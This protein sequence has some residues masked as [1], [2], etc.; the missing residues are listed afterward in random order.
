VVIDRDRD[1]P[2]LGRAQDV[3]CGAIARILDPGGVA[4]VDQDARGKRQPLLGSRDQHDLFGSAAH[5]ARRHQVFGDRGAQP[6][7]TLRIAIAPLDPRPAGHGAR[8]EALPC[9]DETPVD[10]GMAELERPLRSSRRRHTGAQQRGLARQGARCRAGVDRLGRRRER[11]GTRRHVVA[12]ARLGGDVA[13]C[14]QLLEH[15]YDRAAC[16]P[17]LGRER[18]ARRQ[19]RAVGEA[20]FRDRLAQRRGELTRQRNARIAVEPRRPQRRSPLAQRWMRG[21]P[22]G[23]ACGLHRPSLAQNPYTAGRRRGWP[24]LESEGMTAGPLV[25]TYALTERSRAI[26]AEELQA[27]A[28][29]VYLTDLKPE[30]RAE[31]LHSAGALLSHDTSKELHPGEIPLI[32]GARLLQFTAAG[33]DWVP[34]RGLPPELPVAANKGGGAEP[35]AEHIVALALAAAK[36]LFIEHDNL[37]RGEFNQRGTNKMLR[38]GVCGILGFGNVGVATARLMRAFGMRIHAINRRGA[39]EEETDWIATPARLDDMLRAADVFVVSAA[40]TTET[41]G[42]IGAREFSLMQDDA[43]F[44]NVARGEIVDEAALYA[45]LQTHPRFVA[46]I[47]AWWVEP[48][49]HGRFAMGHPFL[50]LPNVIGSPHNS[51]GGGAWRDQYLRRAVANCR[52]AI[53]GEPPH[54]L[55]GPDE[56]ML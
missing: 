4:G 10:L 36:R 19:P 42:L 7:L 31:V 16:Q 33:I 21:R 43:I 40:L 11:L 28:A 45:H 52:R 48:V 17:Q 9:R 34:T 20:T 2:R 29:V 25:V 46:G 5:A 49:R 30:E 44:I 38:G 6:G 8:R 23:W 1:D 14:R 27:A 22:P 39:S 15:Q 35:M 13:F 54:N 37:K 32:R 41:V 24:D 47:D 18:S 56:R 55:I 53:L 50:D 3:E 12:G 51:A 26:V